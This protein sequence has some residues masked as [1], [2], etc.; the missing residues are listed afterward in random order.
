[1]SNITFNV[2]KLVEVGAWLDHRHLTGGYGWR[3]DRSLNSIKKII[4]HHT[5]TNQYKN[6]ER[7]VKEIWEHRRYGGT[8]YH[9]IITSEEIEHNGIRYAKVSYCGDVGSIRAHAV[10]DKGK[11]GLAARKGNNYSLG[12]SFI[13]DNR[14]KYPSAAML[15]SAKLLIEELFNDGRF[16]A[17]SN[18]IDVIGHGYWDY[19]WCP[20]GNQGFNLIPLI[21]NFNDPNMSFDNDYSK[22]K[23]P[24]DANHPQ[25]QAAIEHMKAVTEKA[26]L[27]PLSPNT[28]PQDWIGNTSEENLNRNVNLGT[29]AVILTK[30][31]YNERSIIKGELDKA[32]SDLNIDPVSKDEILKTVIDALE[33][34][35]TQE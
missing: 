27:T 32:I 14:V 15:R 13:G 17:L 23:A 5:V 12:I 31:R 33:A 2:P 18:K 21:L 10:N 11:D 19:T 6:A 4:V 8:P 9:F 1:M 26:K 3:G 25:V 35:T 20:D 24:L 28:V 30:F 22:Y 34:E 29:L 7:E 16:T